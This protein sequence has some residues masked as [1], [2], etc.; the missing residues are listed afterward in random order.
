MMET[1]LADLD[2][3]FG[4]PGEISF[5]HGAGGLVLVEVN[6][7]QASATITLQG[8]QLVSWKPVG[9]QAVIWLSGD[10][11]FAPGKSI[12]GGIPVCW[13][14]FGPHATDPELPAHGFARTADWA[15][16][17]TERRDD[18][19]SRLVFLLLQNDSTRT[20]WPFD[21]QLVLKITIG[22]QLE[23]ELLTRNTGDEALVIGQAL[24]TYFEVSDVRD[25]VIQG[26][27]GCTYIDKLDHNNEKLQSAPVVFESET[28]RIYLD[29]SKECVIEDPG[30]KRR[31]R[32]HKA[33]SRSTVV[34]N[35][36][37]E[38]SARMGDMGEN[39]YLHMLCVESANAADDVVT[40]EP[41]SEHC[42][43]VVYQLQSF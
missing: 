21:A 12:R 32:I 36:W 16:I 34:W 17:E 26:L 10:A 13:P 33:G 40:V 29:T 19:S 42:L 20:A 9:Q 6:N 1:S 22:E 15:L 24:H 37:I 18:G 7:A 27:E 3:A 5:S 41:G 2:A 25:V 43:S 38:K 8:A 4:I 23:M 28:D 30:M 11:R 14:W 35:P 39:G 31:I